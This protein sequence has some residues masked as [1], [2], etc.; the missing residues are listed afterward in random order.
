M[1]DPVAIGKA[2]VDLGGWTAFVIGVVAFA[3]AIV[4]GY[5]V[6]GFVYKREVARADTATTQAERNADAIED[7]TDVL[8][9]RPVRR[10][11][12][13]VTAG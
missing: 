11:R 13:S 9:N 1:P 7:L 4:R 5:L 3:F 12:A 2:L 8:A 6:P 10:R